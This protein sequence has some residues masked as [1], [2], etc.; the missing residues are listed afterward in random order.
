M[1]RVKAHFPKKVSSTSLWASKAEEMFSN[2][3]IEAVPGGEETHIRV[4]LPHHCIAKVSSSWSPVNLTSLPLRSRSCPREVMC[5]LLLG[6]CPTDG[7]EG[8]RECME[9]AAAAGPGDDTSY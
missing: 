2:A 9:V 5:S 6:P 1:Q 7:A 4:S 8:V 3:P